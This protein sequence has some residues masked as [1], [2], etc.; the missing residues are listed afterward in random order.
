MATYP[1]G[2]I[3]TDALR[4]V[5]AYNGQTAWLLPA[6]AASLLRIQGECQ[7]RYGWTPLVTSAGDGFRS[8]DRQVAVF[9]QRYRTTYATVLVGGRR[10]VDRRV[11]DGVAY[12][13][14]TGAAAAV[15]GTSNHGKGI[16]ADL[17]G[18]GWFGATRFNEAYRLLTAE[19]WSN[20]EG[21][22]VSEPWHWNY[23]RDAYEV[24]DTN[25]IPGVD[26]T[27]V[28]IPDLP[29]PIQKVKDAML[30][31]IRVNDD[32]PRNAGGIYLVNLVQP[33]FMALTPAANVEVDRLGVGMV[34]VTSVERD[35][36]RQ[37]VVDL[38][39]S[40]GRIDG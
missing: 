9:R 29:D 20:T 1:N 36:V 12:Y 10:V 21:R 32:Q 4:P 15:P 34:T 8:Y 17:S 35:Q 13:R 28:T 38:Q 37:L 11:W 6:P 19:G 27:P 25:T 33:Q 3:P 23:I 2:Q 16:T 30:T 5:P 39:A 7:R 31:R 40:E 24:T 26:I 18:L 14:W 22:S